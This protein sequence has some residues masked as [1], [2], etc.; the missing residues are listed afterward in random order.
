MKLLLPGLLVAMLP[1]AALAQVKD[2][3]LRI[4]AGRRPFEACINAKVATARAMRADHQWLQRLV[5]AEC[6]TEA[7]ALHAVV[8]EWSREQNPSAAA[9]HETIAALYVNRVM[10]HRVYGAGPA[11]FGQP[12]TSS[13]GTTEQT[14][15]NLTPP[16]R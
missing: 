4:A 16:R 9:S 3:D 7:N 12:E 5:E 6:K 14:Q 8:L 11:A 13:S 15:K 10:F 1:C 2:D